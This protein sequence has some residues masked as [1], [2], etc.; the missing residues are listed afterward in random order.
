V[1]QHCQAVLL[2]RLCAQGF[3]LHYRDFQ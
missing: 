2:V 3:C 1:L